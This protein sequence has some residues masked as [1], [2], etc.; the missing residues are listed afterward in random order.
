M[1]CLGH[2]RIATNQTVIK[3]ED[4]L[5]RYIVLF[6]S[7]FML[8]KSIELLF[9]TSGIQRVFPA[10]FGAGANNQN[11]GACGARYRQNDAKSLMKRQ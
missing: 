7:Y 10:T 3:Q 8:K 11:V 1:D 2:R 5:G 6:K 9:R 4:K